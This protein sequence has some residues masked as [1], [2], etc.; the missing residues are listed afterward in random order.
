MKN[1]F[2]GMF[3]FWQ[4]NMTFMYLVCYKY[5]FFRNFFNWTWTYRSDSDFVDTYGYFIEKPKNE[6]KSWIETSHLN[7]Y[8]CLF[9]DL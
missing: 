8:V 6:Q 3:V 4:Q 9:L 1:I 2:Q 5:I 7:M